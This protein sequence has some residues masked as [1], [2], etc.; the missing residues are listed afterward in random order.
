MNRVGNSLN[1]ESSSSRKA[2]TNETLAHRPSLP[3]RVTSALC[4][5]GPGQQRSKL[6][7]YAGLP[8]TCSILEVDTY[9][10]PRHAAP[11]RSSTI[12]ECRRL[13]LN[14][15]CTETAVR[16]GTEADGRMHAL[17]AP[18]E[19]TARAQARPPHH[20]PLE[21]YSQQPRSI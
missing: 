10:N 8:P 5:H 9:S 20:L 17:G 4:S 18:S 14:T 6:L 21:K 11:Q 1:R 7:L 2:G 16:R 12:P 13:A 19:A 3:S 15:R